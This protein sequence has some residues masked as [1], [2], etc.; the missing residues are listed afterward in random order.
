VT[1]SLVI[2]PVAAPVAGPQVVSFSVDCDAVEHYLNFAPAGAEIPIDSS[3]YCRMLATLLEL[4]AKHHIRATWFCIADR[5]HDA[6]TCRL[7]RQITA[8]GHQIGNHTYSHPDLGVIGEA[9]RV[10]E[11]RRAHDQIVATLGVAPTGFRA[12]A[13]FVTPAMLGEL[14]ELGYRYDSSVCY[15]RLFDLA[16]DAMGLL[17]PSF[18]RKQRPPVLGRL[19]NMAPSRLTLPEGTLLEWP[20]PQVAGLPFYGTLH[21]LLPRGVF[22]AQW[23]QARWSR[24]HTH[25]EIHPI[26]VLASEDAR[27]YPWVPTAGLSDS[28]RVAWLDRRLAALAQSHVVTLEELS[29]RYLPAVH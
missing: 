15:S 6:E 19:S 29:D 12:P 5:L 18:S 27:R 13:Y 25:Y 17:R 28:K 9:E 8:A 4:F 24:H 3:A 7:F 22:F 2:E 20:I 16:I 11:V 21:A 10:A 26:E 1:Q 23:Q 14:C